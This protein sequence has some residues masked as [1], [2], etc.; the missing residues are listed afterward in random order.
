MESKNP[1]I[2]QKALVCLQ[3][4][5]Q[6]C[7]NT[8]PLYAETIKKCFLNKNPCV[9]QSAINVILSEIW[10]NEDVF[11]GLIPQLVQIQEQIISKKM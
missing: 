3:K 2:V 11:Q 1:K 10:K 6:L 7:P 9:V 8:I 4:I 5:E